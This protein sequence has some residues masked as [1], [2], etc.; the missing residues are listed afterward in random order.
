MPTSSGSPPFLTLKVGPAPDKT[1][2]EVLQL[3]QLD[4]QLALMAFGPQCKDVEDQRRPVHDPAIQLAFKISLLRGRDVVVED[5][6][7]RAIHLS[8]KPD[9]VGLA[10]AHVEGGVGRLPT[11]LN[12][13]HDRCART[14]G[15]QR[16]L[17]E[18]FFDA[19]LSEI[20]LNQ[21]GS[22]SRSGSLKHDSTHSFPDRNTALGNGTQLAASFCSC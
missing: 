16:N 17:R 3:G 14:T 22:V 13:G 12:H 6:E 1:S 5:D 7:I 11:P 15:Q 4:L 19:A 18:A 20:N 8:R 9:L 2:G 21:D 10:L